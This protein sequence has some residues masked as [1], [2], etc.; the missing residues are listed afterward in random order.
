MDEASDRECG[1]HETPHCPPRT[2]C[3]RPPCEKETQ[4]EK[5]K[6]KLAQYLDCEIN[7]G[8][9]AGQAKPDAMKRE[10]ARCNHLTGGR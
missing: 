2:A 3:A 1:D 4:A 5:R 7:D 8:G 6:K 9:G 10:F